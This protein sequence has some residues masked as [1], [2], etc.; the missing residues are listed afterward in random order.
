M[1][2]KRLLSILILAMLFPVDAQTNLYLFPATNP[3]PE[4]A[5]SWTPSASPGV[6]NQFIYVGGGYM[7]FTNKIPVGATS[8]N[9][10]VTNLSYGGTYY[11][12]ATAT[13]GVTESQFS[14]VVTNQVR[15][16]TTAPG[17]AN[18][19]TLFVQSKSQITD[20]WSDAGMWWALDATNR[21][22]FYRV[23]IAASKP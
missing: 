13:D 23:M 8:T 15:N 16:M 17:M 2:I 4:C 12:A 10:T 21:N 7:Q 3:V 11:F 1:K 5:L 19:R 22:Q 14:N 18:P 20:P 6:T 9:Y